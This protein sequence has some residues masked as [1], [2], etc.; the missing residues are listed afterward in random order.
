MAEDGF[1]VIM[2]D[3]ES[4]SELGLA[5]AKSISTSS[6][7]R[8]IFMGG[9]VSVESDVDALVQKAVD[10]FGGLDVVS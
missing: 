9:D 8:V 4:K 10:E 2:N 3:L 7:Q 5:A 1:N 6:G